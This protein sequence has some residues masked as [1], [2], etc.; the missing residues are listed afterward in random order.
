[1]FKRIKKKR[2]IFFCFKFGHFHRVDLG[3]KNNFDTFVLVE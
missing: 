3:N 2:F 1:M